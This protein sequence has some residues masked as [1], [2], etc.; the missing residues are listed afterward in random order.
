MPFMYLN[1]SMGRITPQNTLIFKGFSQKTPFETSRHSQKK[2]AICKGKVGFKRNLYLR[3]V[4][5]K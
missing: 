3:N 2:T 5:F 1:R 4:S